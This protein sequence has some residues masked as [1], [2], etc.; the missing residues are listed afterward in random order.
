MT[1]IIFGKELTEFLRD[2]R[3]IG[4]IA[5][6]VLLL[7]A[8]SLDGWNRAASDMQARQAAV[9]TD[10]EV[11][12]EQGENNPHGAAH[13]ARYAFR[14]TPPLAAFDP[15]IFDFAGAAF[16]MEAHTQNPTTLRRAEDAAVQAPFPA[17]SPAWI[18]QVVGTLALV[19]LLFPSIAGERQQGTLRALSGAG[20]PPS[21]FAWGKV[22]TAFLFVGAMAV[23]LIL[24]PVLVGILTGAGGYSAMRLVSLIL[25]Y[26]LGLI[27]FSF[28]VLWLSARS[29]T[30]S[31]AF[32][33]AASAWLFVAL[34]WP[35]LAG[36][37]AVTLF[38]DIDEQQLKNDI[39][40]HAQSPFWS[41]ETEERAAA[42][43]SL[44][45]RVVAEFGAESF[46]SLG[47]DRE[48]LILQ[49]HEEFANAVYDRIYGEL[50]A[51]HSGQDAVL[52]Y[53]SVVSPV[54]ALQRLSSGLSGTDLLA[55]QRFATQA[56]AHRRL[57]IEQLN[58][59]MMVNA[60][61]QAFSYMAGRE[62]WESIPEFEPAPPSLGDVFQYYLFE[63]GVLFLWLLAAGWLAIAAIRNSLQQGAR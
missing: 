57:I 39:Q 26:A 40:I 63:L 61:D 52:R 28:F 8:A 32:T 30:L 62:L 41:G 29:A 46:D 10:R 9:A 51:T 3:F 27:G 56:E 42:I 24:L 59:D 58:H 19:I 12:V 14:E 15:G 1:G 43:A 38:P 37:F 25:V 48:A 55:Q 6:L 4:I 53:A 7:A 47:F 23:L 54:L 17:L 22:S 18:V 11:W 2:R 36:Q 5:I 50:A 31:K 60:G 13:F 16:W 34:L 44:E 33:L 35:A 45:A 20:V 49:A 21:S